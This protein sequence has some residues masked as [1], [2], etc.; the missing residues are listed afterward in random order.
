MLSDAD[1]DKDLSEM[2][3]VCD[4]GGGG[5]CM[6]RCVCLSKYRINCLV[7]AYPCSY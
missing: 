4:D 6:S 7:I 2:M 1:A 5:L 3:T